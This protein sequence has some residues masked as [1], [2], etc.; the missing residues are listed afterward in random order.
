M[1]LYPKISINYMDVRIYCSYIFFPINISPEIELYLS[2]Q[3]SFCKIFTCIKKNLQT[4]CLDYKSL[5]I[6]L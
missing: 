4:V 6:S 1:P 5:N 3:D 2:Y